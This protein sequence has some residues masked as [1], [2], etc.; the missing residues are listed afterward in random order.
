M[1]DILRLVYEY[2]ATI[3]KHISKFRNKFRHISEHMEVGIIMT[4][5]ELWSSF[6]DEEGDE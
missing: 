3:A 4:L 6:D 5:D 2:T 1:Y